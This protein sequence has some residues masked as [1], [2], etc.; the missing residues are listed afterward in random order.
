MSSI[1]LLQASSRSTQDLFAWRYTDGKYKVKDQAGDPWPD[2]PG[3]N[4]RRVIAKTSLHTSF[5][6]IAKCTSQHRSSTGYGSLHGS[7]QLYRG[8]T[9]GLPWKWSTIS[10][11]CTGSR[12]K[13]T[14][15]A[16][17]K[18]T[19]TDTAGDLARSSPTITSI[20]YVVS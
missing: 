6:S 7:C 15:C 20:R 4:V 10:L 11:T 3:S 12:K 5:L 18:R 16:Q 19:A 8:R 17:Y 13:S 1:L 14:L 9:L 2:K